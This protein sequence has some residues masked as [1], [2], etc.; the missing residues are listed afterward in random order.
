MHHLIQLTLYASNTV[1]NSQS[2]QTPRTSQSYHWP[3]HPPQPISFSG[4]ISSNSQPRL[5][6]ELQELTP[7]A[8][9]LAATNAHREERTLEAALTPQIVPFGKV[10]QDA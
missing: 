2:K 9:D 3:H 10:R 6:F 1:V 4:N 7:P 8:V 5:Y